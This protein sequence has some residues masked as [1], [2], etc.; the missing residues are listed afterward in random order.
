MRE[1][2]IAA[3]RIALHLATLAAIALAGQAGQRW[4]TP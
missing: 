4:G 2:L 3:I 1:R